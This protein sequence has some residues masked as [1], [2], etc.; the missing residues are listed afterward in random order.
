[1]P[2]ACV[3]NEIATLSKVSSCRPSAT[4]GRWPAGSVYRGEPEPTCSHTRLRPSR[5]SSVLSSPASTCAWV[6]PPLTAQHQ[7]TARHTM[8]DSSSKLTHKL[9]SSRCRCIA[10]NLVQVQLRA[11]Y[12]LKAT[13]AAAGRQV[14]AGR[15]HPPSAESIG[16]AHGSNTAAG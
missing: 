9:S 2:K 7:Q 14:A 16:Q 3:V 13:L 1:V 11:H 4:A 5:S 8:Q 12:L 15:M 10:I 6:H